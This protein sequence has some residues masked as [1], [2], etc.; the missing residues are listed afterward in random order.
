MEARDKDLAAMRAALAERD[1]TI[2]ALQREANI[3]HRQVAEERAERAAEAERRQA[4]EMRCAAARK[5]RADFS[6]SSDY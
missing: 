3:L 2:D 1:R 6:V 4:A 5:Q